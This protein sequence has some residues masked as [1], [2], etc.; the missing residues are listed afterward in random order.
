[1]MDL[2][3]C[4]NCGKEV[5]TLITDDGT[6]Q[7]YCYH[8]IP[9]PDACLGAV[10][11]SRKMDQLHAAGKLETY[12]VEQRLRD[13]KDPP[14]C[15]CGAVL[16]VLDSELCSKCE[17]E[18]FRVKGGEK[19]YQRGGAKLDHFWRVCWIGRG[20]WSGGLRPGLPGRV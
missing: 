18:A 16:D 13:L 12:P 2:N 19:P 7:R 15:E 3:T 14:R 1:M 20:G 17:D 4:P 8:C 11:I 10:F 9:N 5:L 6:R